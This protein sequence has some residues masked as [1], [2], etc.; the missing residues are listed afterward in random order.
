MSPKWIVSGLFCVSIAAASLIAWASDKHEPTAS[1]SLDL[2]TL[3]Q[4]KLASSQ[5]ITEGLVTKDFELI[6]KGAGE[7]RRITAATKWYSRNDPVFVQYRAELGRDAEKLIHAAEDKNLDA[8]A[9]AYAGSLRTCIACHEYCRDTLHVPAR[10]S[11]R[12]VE[13]IPDTDEEP[14][15]RAATR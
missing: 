4:A 12:A 1:D 5:K 7:W 3:M 11:S 14:A 13:P 15:P 9:Y 6:R 10:H 2:A 8:A